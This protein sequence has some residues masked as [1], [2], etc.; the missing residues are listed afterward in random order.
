MPINTSGVLNPLAHIGCLDTPS[1]C[2]NRGMT[3]IRPKLSILDTRGKNG[4]E[5]LKKKLENCTYIVAR[6]I[7]TFF[8]YVGVQQIDWNQMKTSFIAPFY[9]AT[10][11]LKLTVKGLL[12]KKAAEGC[13]RLQKKTQCWPN[14]ILKWLD[15]SLISKKKSK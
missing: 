13:R 3:N 7:Y 9:F 14:L 10:L 4:K 6:L 11:F 2:E 5:K 12:Q 1:N 8:S 15:L